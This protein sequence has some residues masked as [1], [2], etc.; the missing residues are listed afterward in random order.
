MKKTAKKLKRVLASMMAVIMVLCAV[1]MSGDMFTVGAESVQLSA[2]DCYYLG[3]YPQSKITDE[4]TIEALNQISCEW[5]S[6]NYYN[7]TGVRS[8]YMKYK[9]VQYGSNKYRAITFTEFR[10]KSN[11]STNG[12][13]L[14]EVYW[15]LYEPL[16]WKLL[17][18]QTGLSV[19]E[20]VIDSHNYNHTSQTVNG[21]YGN[22][23]EK[24]DIRNWLLNSFY[25]TAIM[26]NADKY[27]LEKS[28]DNSAYNSRYS[29]ASTSDKVFLL[30]KWEADS[31]GSANRKAKIT[32]YSK[33]K[34]VWV[35]EDGC[36]QNWL[37]RTAADNYYS[38]YYTQKKWGDYITYYNWYDVEIDVNSMGVRPAI[39]LD[40]EKYNDC[41]W[42]P[43][44][45]PDGYD[46]NTDRW[47]FQNQSTEIQ[48]SKYYILFGV[49]NGNRIYNQYHDDGTNGQCYGMASTTSSI[50]SHNNLLNS[51][52]H[53]RF[54]DV[55]LN[56]YSDMIGMTAADFIQYG[57][58]AQ[59]DIEHYNNLDQLYE[60][61]KEYINGKSVPIVVDIHGPYNGGTAGH[62][63]YVVGIKE[64]T[65][66]K[67]VLWVDDSNYR[68]LGN[69]L[70]LQLKEL[71][72]LKSDGKISGWRYHMWDG[73]DWGEDSNKNINYS[74]PAELMYQIGL[75]YKD[76]WGFLTRST[77]EN[78]YGILAN[79]KNLLVIDSTSLTVSC[80]DKFI[81]VENNI[82]EENDL[83]YE[84]NDI[85]NPEAFEGFYWIKSK[86]SV[87]FSNIN[88]DS[89]ISLS[90]A[91]SGIEV[92]VPKGAT[93]KAEVSEDNNDNAEISIKKDD[94]V[95]ID[96][97][98]ADSADNLLSLTVSGTASA[99]TITATQTET[100]L[101]V[102]GISDGTV[103]LSKDDEV[104]ETQTIT[105]SVS[106]V[107]ITY[108]KTGE[109]EDI[110]LDY[111]HNHTDED[112]NGK[113]DV[114]GETL[115]AVKNCTHLCHKT[116]FLGFIWKIINFFNKLFGINKTC[117]CGMRHY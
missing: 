17:N 22:N 43:K 72:L 112:A 97:Q 59:Y 89:T 9:D 84:L 105:N 114:C 11:Q 71:T 60:L 51:F 90:D 1:P 52:G 6:C 86:D 113:C 53:Q 27:I 42:E 28:I 39:Y 10:P 2:G 67:C 45:F 116:G 77:A 56:D 104:I 94:T 108:D 23:Y 41:K 106:D 5:K 46:F 30:S 58:L 13:K 49:I 70:P 54:V 34:G 107:E 63:L 3:Y 7:S 62:A 14:N 31:I 50:N 111:E 95:T 99:D 74:C 65:D 21:Y 55:S 68:G 64:D 78:S 15:F 88:D 16:K 69:G 44:I 93:L 12:Y 4:T 33:S 40:V 35:N 37:L 101:I 66:S 61:V 73:L 47:S 87:T 91:D 82:A 110:S 81:N 29:A 38:I 115:D 103:T 36:A 79:D 80:G 117:S 25:Q 20:Y 109:S 85:N 98:N 75:A 92:S 76:K 102:T 26:D 48:K 18:S 8:D 100:G 32:D 57:Q 96:F 24:S 83:M 19:C